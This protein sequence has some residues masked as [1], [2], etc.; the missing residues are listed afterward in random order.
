MQLTVTKLN[1][2]RR[3]RTNTHHAPSY[4]LLNGILVRI[5]LTFRSVK[6]ANKENGD[7]AQFF[8]FAQDASIILSCKLHHDTLAFRTGSECHDL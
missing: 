6:I 7:S 5:E 3:Y 2:F 8:F 4:E 1:L